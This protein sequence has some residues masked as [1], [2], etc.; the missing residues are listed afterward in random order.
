MEHIMRAILKQTWKITRRACA[1]LVA[2]VFVTV[3]LFVANSLLLDQNRPVVIRISSATVKQEPPG[4]IRVLTFNVHRCGAVKKSSIFGVSFG[5]SD[6][7]RDKVRQ[8]AVLLR[9]KNADIVILNEICLEC[10]PTGVNQVEMLAREAGYPYAVFGHNMN[11]GLPFFRHRE[12]NAILSRFPIA[13]AENIN[14]HE[15][16]SPLSHAANRRVLKVAINLAGENITVFAVHLPANHPAQNLEQ[17]KALRGRIE[18]CGGSVIVAGDF[19]ATPGSATMLEIG[20]MPNI[21][22]P[23]EC[24]PTYVKY[25]P[26]RIIDFIFGPAAWRLV[27]YE[28][29]QSDLSDH[30]PVLAVFNNN[31]YKGSDPLYML[32]GRG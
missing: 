24:N 31:T 8:I 25:P 28:T 19:N 15:P 5:D 6:S 9:E 10:G 2:A 21:Q 12:G 32:S 7:V 20:A 16:R 30:Y 18:E 27:S 17:A 14:L 29:I 26:E 13:A 4:M 11:F 3:V 1:I 23:G 22:Q